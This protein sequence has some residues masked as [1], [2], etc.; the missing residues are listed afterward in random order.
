ML[1]L[2]YLLKRLSVTV[3]GDDVEE[4]RTRVKGG[5]RNPSDRDG[6]RIKCVSHKTCPFGCVC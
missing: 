1:V 6:V 3:D 5:R 4:I 2:V